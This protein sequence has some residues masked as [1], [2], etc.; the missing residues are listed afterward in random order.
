MDQMNYYYGIDNSEWEQPLEIVQDLKVKK[1]M[2]NSTLR[3]NNN[4]DE[5]NK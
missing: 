5:K 4:I 3:I 1:K 2:V